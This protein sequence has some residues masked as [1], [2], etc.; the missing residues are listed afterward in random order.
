MAMTVNK[1][2]GMSD[3]EWNEIVK[4]SVEEEQKQ[5]ELAKLRLIKQREVL[6]NELDL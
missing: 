2:V 5:K 1:G 6:K 4:N 3:A